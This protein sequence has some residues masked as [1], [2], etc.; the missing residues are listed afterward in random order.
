MYWAQVKVLL[1]L[2]ALTDI[3]RARQ[4]CKHW[5]SAIVSQ[6]A[7]PLVTKIR[8]DSSVR[9]NAG[10][11]W[12]VQHC[13]EASELHASNCGGIDASSLALQRA[14]PSLRVRAESLAANFRLAASNRCLISSQI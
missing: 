4:V 3:A 1:Q 12:A 6:P 2:D 10:L 11:Q 13:P 8:L 7:W 5:H 9:A 14:L